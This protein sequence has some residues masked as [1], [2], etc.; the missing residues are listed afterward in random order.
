MKK[1]VLVLL[2]I[3]TGNSFSQSI[4][5]GI[6]ATKK[7][8][9]RYVSKDGFVFTIG[10][11]IELGTPSN[12]DVYVYVENEYSAGNSGDYTVRNKLGEICRI[13]H[14]KP[15][16]KGN[17]IAYTDNNLLVF[18]EY[19]IKTQEIINLYTHLEKIPVAT[20]QFLPIDNN[21]ISFAENYNNIF[22][23]KIMAPAFAVAGAGLTTWGGILLGR[24]AVKTNF[25]DKETGGVV[26]C[27]A[28]GC[29]AVTSLVMYICEIGEY[30][31][32]RD[33]HKK[34]QFTGNGV[35]VELDKR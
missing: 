18:I 29:L 22:K 9:E 34:I 1:L 28:G 2:L 20:P 16:E 19:A 21:S 25:S 10:D 33:K 14:L 30:K 31:K 6:P 4:Q 26:L 7:K 24:S 11:T 5:Y 12:E 35:V 13:K 3:I 17:M 27:V 8:Y 15:S 23:Y 32:I